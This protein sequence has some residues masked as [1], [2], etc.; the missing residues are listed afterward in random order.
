M[1]STTP[2]QFTI[3]MT[4]TLP[5]QQAIKIPDPPQVIDSETS[6]CVSVTVPPGPNLSCFRIEAGLKSLL[7]FF[8]LNPSI[9]PPPPPNTGPIRTAACRRRPAGDPRTEPARGLRLRDRR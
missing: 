7:K 3:Q 1:A 4:V 6:S 9:P 2:A 5:N 8:L